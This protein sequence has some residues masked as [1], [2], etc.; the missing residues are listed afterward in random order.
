M[1]PLGNYAVHPAGREFA[2]SVPRKHPCRD[3]VLSDS[4]ECDVA[5]ESRDCSRLG[6]ILL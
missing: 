2:S 6:R 5:L 1:T 3:A 4:G